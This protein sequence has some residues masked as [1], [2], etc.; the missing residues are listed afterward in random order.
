VRTDSLLGPRRILEPADRT[1]TSGLPR[2]MQGRRS[3]GGGWWEEGDLKRRLLNH[4]IVAAKARDGFSLPPPRIKKWQ[5]FFEQCGPLF[6]VERELG[7][8]SPIR[9]AVQSLASAQLVKYPRS[10]QSFWHQDR[11]GD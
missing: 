9:A 7:F 1:L 6:F 2:V 3:E 11:L 10:V 5:L 4:L 8:L